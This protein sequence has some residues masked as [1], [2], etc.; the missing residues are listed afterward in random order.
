MKIVVLDGYCLNPGDLSW[1]GFEELGECV[2]YERT[3]PEEIL[4]RAKNAEVLLTNKT[5]ITAELIEKLPDLKYIGVLATGYNV[6]DLEAAASHHIVVTNIP[7]YSTESVAQL[8]FAHILN[9]TTSVNHYAEQSR[10]GVWSQ[11]EDFSYCDTQLTELFGKKIGIVGLGNIGR[12]VARIAKAFGMIVYAC[13]SSNISRL[14]AGTIKVSIDVLFRECDVVTMHCPLREN[15]HGIVNASLLETMKPTAIFINTARGQL[16]NEQ[17][18]AD[19]LNSGKLCAA[20]LDV[21]SLEPPTFDNP[22]LKARNCFITPHIAWASF[23]A[24]ERL[25]IQAVANLQAFLK[26]APVNVVSYK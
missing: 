22:L 7:A 18:L 13:T 6:V 23:D 20:A 1:K 16:V 5:V 4:D 19:A 8:V 9:I 15:N 17:D 10:Q 21:M 2:V 26:G 12:A 24:R 14:P 3:K 11:K 25:M